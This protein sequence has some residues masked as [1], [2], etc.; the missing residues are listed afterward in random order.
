MRPA[1]RVRTQSSRTSSN[2]LIRRL[3]AGRLWSDRTVIACSESAVTV[4]GFVTIL[5]LLQFHQRFME[6]IDMSTNT[7]RRTLCIA[8]PLAAVL[9]PAFA[10]TV[11]DVWKSPTCGCCA[12]WVTHLEKNGFSV[13]THD[14]GNTARRRELGMP[15]RYGSCHTALVSG[16]VVEG[17]VP[18]AD[19]ARLLKERPDALGIA[20]PNMPVGSPGMDG[21][22]YGGRRDPYDVLLVTRDGA[23]SVYVSH[24]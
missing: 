17:H 10:T 11:I 3:R 19:I 12:A 2:D 7:L 20:V 4:N 5:K 23:A 14:T 6:R 15:V 9:R 1:D 16:Y 13:R 24:R 22:V 18:A 21:P 8:L